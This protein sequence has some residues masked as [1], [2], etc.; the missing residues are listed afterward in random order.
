MVLFE[1]EH[2][3]LCPSKFLQKHVKL[4]FMKI[5]ACEN[6]MPNTLQFKLAIK[7]YVSQFNVINDDNSSKNL[8]NQNV[9]LMLVQENCHSDLE[10][11]FSEFHTHE[12]G[13][14]RDM[15]LSPDDDLHMEVQHDFEE[16][17]EI[18]IKEE[19][20]NEDPVFGQ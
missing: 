14:Q 20:D 7:K 10:P 17:D 3:N 16:D 11:E 18:N 5:T 4:W 13:E 2:N 15:R 12:N 8:K 6:V 19:L 1:E 9:E